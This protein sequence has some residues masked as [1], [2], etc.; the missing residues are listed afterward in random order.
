MQFS[1][2]WLREWANP[3]VDTN[4]L[5]ER[6][7]MAG[8]KVESVAPAAAPFDGVVIGEVQTVRSHPDAAQLTVCTVWDGVATQQVVCGAP[9]VR[10]GMRT[11]YARVGARLPADKQIKAAKLRGVE[12]FGML[13]S[14]AELGIGD[15]ADGIMDLATE[16]P[17]GESLRTA[18][19]LDDAII[20]LDLTP[21]RGD[22]LSIRGVAREVGV[23]F[24]AAVTSPDCDPVEYT[25]DDAFPVRLDDGAGCPCYLGR[26]IR[27]IDVRAATPIWMKER[28]RRGG[29][30]CIDPVVDVT[31]YVMLELGQPMH[32]FDLDRLQQRIVVRKA[33]DGEVLTLLDGQQV[34]LDHNTLLITDAG[35]P[36]AIAGVMGGDR[37]G[38]Q[39]TTRDVFVECAFFP[40][41][42]VAGTARRYGLQTDASQRF[43]RG[44]DRRLQAAAM[45]RATALLLAIVGGRPGPVV[46][47]ISSAHLPAPR[48]IVLR[49]ERLNLYVGDKTD[50]D[51]VTDIFQR[52]GFTPE[53]GRSGGNRIWSV[54]VPSHRFDVEREVDLIEE[55]CRIR[56]YHVI[57]A[58]MP[59]ARLE[60]GRVPLVV[61]PRDKVR[62]LLADLGYQEAVTYSFIDPIFAD[63]LTPGESPVTLTNPMSADLSVMR[64]SLW[65]GLVK[66]L[67]A[68]TSRQ[69]TRVRL[70]E[71]GRCFKPGE[72]LRQPLLIGGVVTG[73]RLPENWTTPAANVDFFDVKGDVERVLEQN[74]HAEVAYRPADDPILHPGQSATV[75]SG[76]VCLG[77]LGRLHPELEH[78]LDLKASAFVFELDADAVLARHLPV[79][80]TLSRYPS[81]RRDLS[82]ELAASVPAA[83]VRACVERALGPALADFRLF[84]VYQGEGIDS[85][86]KSIAVG[87]TLQD[88][89]RTLT[90]VD[91]NALMDTVVSAL[92]TDLGARRR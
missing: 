4:G 35:G 16:A 26:V 9:N 34:K 17:A 68:N 36:I 75:W 10:A 59:T 72:E 52:L 31:N 65:P 44:V 71:V 51:E 77:R 6:L 56:G 13:C 14:A 42:A 48:T 23:L 64:V 49:N 73:S 53:P 29:L 78:R 79:Y 69:Q 33:R 47:T 24:G 57:P 40:P 32:A 1:E 12:S 11:A 89:S 38:I 87:L 37:S 8:I 76:T 41:L 61:T 7:T 86:K 60:L 19:A 63:L 92:E 5:V 58:R 82:L 80:Q 83:A 91:I 90:D 46:E 62:Q 55:V 2:T 84:D 27:G 66:T 22:C 43:E 28:L 21:N 18:L 70:F 74:G 85:A 20:E 54:T 50:P 25:I 3:A 39:P 45:E 15:D 67:I 81:V 30:R 88:H